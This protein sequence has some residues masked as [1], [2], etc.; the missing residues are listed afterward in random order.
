MVSLVS[1]KAILLKKYQ[2]VLNRI[3]LFR[4]RHKEQRK[5]R[6]KGQERKTENNFAVTSVTHLQ[7]ITR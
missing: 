3:L 7:Q 2:Y 4:S 6:D 5:R 1:K